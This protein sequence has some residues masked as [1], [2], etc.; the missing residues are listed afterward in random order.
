MAGNSYYIEAT[1]NDTTGDGSQ[2]NPWATLEKAEATAADG[3][4]VYVGAGTFEAA[5]YYTFAKQI[6]WITSSGAILRGNNGSRLI[7]LNSTKTKLFSGFILDG[8]SSGTPPAYHFE[9]S[10]VNQD[11]TFQN[12]Q[13]IHGNT[14]AARLNSAMSGITLMMCTFDVENEDQVI[15]LLGG[16]TGFTMSG[17]TINVPDGITLSAAIYQAAAVTSASILI[18]GNTITMLPNYAPIRLVAGGI[19]S[20]S[21]TNNTITAAA[22]NARSLIELK[23]IEGTCTISGNTITSDSVSEFLRPISLASTLVT[24]P[25]CVYTIENNVMEFRKAD[26]YGILIGD[27]GGDVISKA[28]AFNGSIIK[29]N[30][31][32]AAPYFGLPIGNLHGIMMGGNINFFY[33]DNYIYGAAYG[34]V[35]KGKGEVWTDGHIYNNVFIH[36]QYPIR[37]KGQKNMRAYHNVCIGNADTDQCMAISDNTAPG[38]ESTGT[39]TRNQIYSIVSGYA[40]YT[41]DTSHVGMTSDYNCFHLTGTAKAAFINGVEYATLADLQAAGYDLHSVEGDPNLLSNNLVDSVSICHEAGTPI[42]GVT[43]V[44][45]VYN[46]MQITFEGNAVFDTDSPFKNRVKL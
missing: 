9:G 21:I 13:F 32:K 29:G 24:G 42:D 36:C 25:N 45:D 46:M 31:M 7:Y 33:E 11:T 20:L 16:D 34:A 12:C 38:T 43:E 10:G 44:Y 8:D 3:D 17:C 27:E 6:S 4:S 35:I 41:Q 37:Y 2:F 40:I 15:Y 5:T 1:G 39:Y 18:S 28:G 19:D 26:G 30:V 14:T 22:N 23:D